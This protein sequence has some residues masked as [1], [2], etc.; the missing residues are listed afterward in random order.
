MDASELNKALS[1]SGEIVSSDVGD[2]PIIF[3]PKMAAAEEQKVE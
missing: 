1:R 3:K 2:A